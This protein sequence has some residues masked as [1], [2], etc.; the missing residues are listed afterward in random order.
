MKMGKKLSA[1]MG[2][3]GAAMG[4]AGLFIY[5]IWGEF[6]WLFTA[7]EISAAILL[8]VFFVT[9]FEMLRDF[10][11][12]R[13]TKFGLNSIVMVII[14]TAI[15]GIV[16]FIL[17]RHEL[18][19]DLSDS[20]AF[21]LSQQTKTILENLKSDIKITGFF[22]GQSKVRARAED[23][24]KNYKHHSDKIS[25]TIVDPDKKPTLAKQYSIT[26]YDTIVLESGGQSATAR[27]I[28]ESGLT[29]AMI[30]ISRDS[31]KT[32][33][34]V[35]GHGERPIDDIGKDGFSNLKET[36]GRQGFFVKKLLLLGRK[37]IPEDADVVIIAGPT[38]LFTDQEKG[39]LSQYLKTGGQLFMLIDP[40]VETGL[41]TFLAEW[42]IRI[43]KGI[44][45]DPKSGLGGAIPTI[46]PG[47]YLPHEIT[48]DFNLA[49]FFPVTRAIS[50][51]L[52]TGTERRFDPFLESSP[53]TW[54][55]EEAD[56]NLSID[57]KRDRKGPIVFGGVVTG[58]QHAADPSNPSKQMRLVVI[59]DSDFGTNSVV[60]A[61]GNG[62]LFLNVVS[63][64]A[65]EGDLVS[66]RPQEVPTTNLVL[67]AQQTN[68][69]FSVSVLILPLGVMGVGL[70][71]WRG[72]RRL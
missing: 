22:A 70:F 29:S 32:F 48:S 7:I 72:R 67:S 26:D 36:L 16:N 18:R 44:I 50:F 20:G 59:G 54:L 38:R 30:R 41:E 58:D 1:A 34:F 35:E 43:D 12:Q 65:D 28:S 60:R 63:W 45:L 11:S 66:I 4:I 57:P 49:T 14:F 31:K 42:G 33:Y 27:A 3:L 55:T 9:H 10:S 24:M 56:G 69:I 8:S 40:I 51:D 23:L 37:T 6:V 13:S 39:L 68:A 5:F 21:S 52:E 71:I 62:D 19:I 15:L 17:V 64:L 2:I 53:N 47:S 25:Y 61:A 46:S